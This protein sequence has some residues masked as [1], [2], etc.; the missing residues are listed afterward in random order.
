MAEGVQYDPGYFRGVFSVSESGVLVYAL[1]RPDLA[2]RLTWLDRAGKPVGEPFGEPAEYS[3]LS[4]APDGKRIAA[5]INDSATG[6]A[7]IWLFDTRGVRTRF[8]F[9]ELAEG[10]CGRAT[11][12]ASRSRD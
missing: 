7:S 5:G 10:R 12:A 1:G 6:V 2:T 11:E 4:V 8:T 3:S 9:G